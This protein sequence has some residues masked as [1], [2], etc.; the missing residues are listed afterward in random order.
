MFRSTATGTLD[1]WHLSQRFLTP[2]GINQTF[3]EDT[4]PMSRILAAG[5]QAAG[6]QYLADIVINRR[7]TR[8]IPQYGTPVS[9]GRF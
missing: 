6:Q 2:P 7:A 4:P 8:P 3:I 5:A 9:L 1:A